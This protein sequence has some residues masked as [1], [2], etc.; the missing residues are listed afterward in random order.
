MTAPPN[1]L[2]S[3][4]HLRVLSPGERHV[5]RFAIAVERLLH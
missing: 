2:V 5:A 3:G 4:D 1:A